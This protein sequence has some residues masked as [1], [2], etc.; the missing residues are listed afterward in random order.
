MDL[1]INKYDLVFHHLGL[2][3]KKPDMASNFLHGLGYSVDEAVSDPLQK[4]SLIWCKHQIMPDVEIIYKNLELEDS[5]LDGIFINRSELFYHI[6]YETTDLNQSIELMKKD[7][8]LICISPAKE[9][10]LF[11]FRKVSFYIVRGFGLIE[12][13]EDF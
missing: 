4:V 12:I 7:N 11:E 3:T 13:L 10:I 1:K 2:A 9:A 6:C 5:P 8:R